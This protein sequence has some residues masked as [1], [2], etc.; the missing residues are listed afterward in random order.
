MHEEHKV[1]RNPRLNQM[2]PQWIFTIF[3]LYL[4]AIVLNTHGDCFE[5][6]RPVFYCEMLDPQRTLV[7]K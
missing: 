5:M 4:I 6:Q 7:R 1:L 2:F 3:E